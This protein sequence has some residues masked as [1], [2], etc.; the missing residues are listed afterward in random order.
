MKTSIERQ[1]EKNRWKQDH[2]HKQRK[3]PLDRSEFVVM[4]T[5]SNISRKALQETKF[6]RCV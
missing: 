6:L 2:N 4:Q 3:L 5:A 1:K